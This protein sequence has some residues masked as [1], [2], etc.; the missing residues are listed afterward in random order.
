MRVGQHCSLSLP[1]SLRG[2]EVGCITFPER[3]REKERQ[4]GRLRA[5]KTNRKEKK[6]KKTII[7]ERERKKLREGK[8]MNEW[9]EKGRKKG[10]RKSV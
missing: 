1:I 3:K 6:M 10:C 9:T 4:R 8:S 7:K 2:R 5:Q